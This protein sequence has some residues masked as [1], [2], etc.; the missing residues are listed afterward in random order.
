[1]RAARSNRKRH[2]PEMSTP[3]ML[4]QMRHDVWAT[5]KLI[6]HCRKLTKEQLELTVPGTYGSIRTTLVHIVAADER[7]LRRF[8][9]MPEPLLD[10]DTNGEATL[11]EIATHLQHVNDGVEKLVSGTNLDPDSGIRRAPP[12]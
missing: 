5:E 4:R 8:M 10:E 9:Q 12:R 3:P 1:A 2:T 7:Y 11:D 6:D